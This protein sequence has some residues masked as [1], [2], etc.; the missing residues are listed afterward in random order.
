MYLAQLK[1]WVSGTALLRVRSFWVILKKSPKS[2]N[3]KRC[4]LSICCSGNT[5]KSRYNM[6]ITVAETQ[7]KTTLGSVAFGVH[8]CLLLLPLTSQHIPKKPQN[9]SSKFSFFNWT[10]FSNTI[11]S[12]CHYA[13][14]R[15]T[16]D[17]SPCYGVHKHLLAAMQVQSGLNRPGGCSTQAQPIQQN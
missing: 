7:F 5:W 9:H 13:L 11:T 4:I 12:E 3:N 15:N 10:T 14:G 8:A 6:T 1:N 2:F 16:S 17:L